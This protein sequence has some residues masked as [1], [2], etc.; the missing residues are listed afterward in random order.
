MLNEQIIPVN[1]VIEEQLQV[2]PTKVSYVYI[3]D[4][5]KTIRYEV[6]IKGKR[7]ISKAADVTE[8]GIKNLQKSLPE[9]IKIVSC[10]TCR[11]GHFNPYG[12][13]DNEIFCLK[14]I[15]PHNLVELR[16]IFSTGADLENRKRHLL[17]Y[18]SKYRP[19]S[20]KDCFTYNDWEWKE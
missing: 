9:T 13:N 11:Y 8:Y 14:D 19:I 12:D 18:C 1:Y 17:D 16:E 6:T 4:E 20:L 7:F 15:Q 10:Q 3:E 5:L 2:I